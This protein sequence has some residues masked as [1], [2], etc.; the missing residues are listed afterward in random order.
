MKN[1][2]QN[3]NPAILI[4]ECGSREHQIVIEPSYNHKLIYCH[5]HLV[6]YGFWERMKAGLKYIFG[7]KCKYGQ[8]EE[9]ILKPEHASQLRKLSELLS[10]YNK[11]TKRTLNKKL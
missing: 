9:F 1:K 5:I 11:S 4:C 7:Y 3:T 6:K 8:W 10:Q 2:E